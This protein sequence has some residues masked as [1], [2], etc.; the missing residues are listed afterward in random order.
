MSDTTGGLRRLKAVTIAC[1][2]I[3]AL[4]A[5]AILATTDA[6]PRQASDPAAA[7]AAQRLLGR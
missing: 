2:L 5:L 1:A 4:S 6:P 7:P 3:Y